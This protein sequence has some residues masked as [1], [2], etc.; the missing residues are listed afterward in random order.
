DQRKE[1]MRARD[2]AETVEDMRTEVLDALVTRF[3]PE[4]AFAEQW[5]TQALHEE[6]RRLFG[7][8]L[9]IADWA[10]EEG[11]ADQ[12]IRERL[13]DAVNR[14]MAEKAA[15]LG[16]DLMRVAEKSILLQL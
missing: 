4:K 12:E 8:D 6:V 3:I 10:K 13:T 5:D 11:I 1:I 9:P 16:P 7:L 15:N 2:V 14:K